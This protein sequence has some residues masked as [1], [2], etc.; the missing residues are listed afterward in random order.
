MVDYIALVRDPRIT[1]RCPSGRSHE[2]PDY[3]FLHGDAVTLA[4]PETDAAEFFGDV[5]GREVVVCSSSWRRRMGNAQPGAGCRFGSLPEF[6]DRLEH[7]RRL[8]SVGM[9]GVHVESAVDA[10]RLLIEISFAPHSDE[11]RVEALEFALA[12]A[13]LELDAEVH[14]RAAGRLHL[15][16]DRSKGWRQFTDHE[17]LP[18]LFIGSEAGDPGLEAPCGVGRAEAASTIG[19]TP[20]TTLRL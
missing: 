14:F 1:D 8:C 5:A 12:A 13:T 15:Q 19:F 7:A 3:V 20:R 6:F 9:G 2:R 11:Q 17:L 18:L 16:G 10:S 4:G